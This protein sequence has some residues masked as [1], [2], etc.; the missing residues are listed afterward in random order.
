MFSAVF[1][2]PSLLPP[3]DSR[4]TVINVDI[5]PLRGIFCA[6]KRGGEESG[7]AKGANLQNLI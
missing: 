5:T 6:P 4:L 3:Y 7:K 2:F 1:E